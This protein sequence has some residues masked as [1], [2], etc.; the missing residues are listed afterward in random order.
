MN[1]LDYLTLDYTRAVALADMRKDIVDRERAIA[2]L[3]P[4]PPRICAACPAAQL[5]ERGEIRHS[6]QAME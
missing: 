5:S 3:P 2:G 6:S 4:I 1:R